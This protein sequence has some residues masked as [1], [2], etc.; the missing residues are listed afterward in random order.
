MNILAGATLKQVSKQ[1]GKFHF[2]ARLAFPC[3]YTMG[4]MQWAALWWPHLLSTSL[5]LQ[6]WAVFVNSFC[7]HCEST[8]LLL[9][10]RLNLISCSHLQTLLHCAHWVS[11]T[12]Q[13][14]C[15][16]LEWSS[17]GRYHPPEFFK[18]ASKLGRWCNLPGLDSGNMVRSWCP[19]WIESG[20]VWW[21]KDL[22]STLLIKSLIHTPATG[23]T[24]QSTKEG[25]SQR[26]L[27]HF[28]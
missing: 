3:K 16:C 1:I 19:T 6:H 17:W 9:H 27:A 24:S 20:S 8:L 23:C 18:C 5:F 11:V 7:S 25:C 26:E 28:F 2:V 15:S 4:F 14:W 22:A 21:V 10:W 13:K 12:V